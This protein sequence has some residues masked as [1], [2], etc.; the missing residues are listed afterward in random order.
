MSQ[1]KCRPCVEGVDRCA[2]LLGAEA[3]P[4]RQY[5]GSAAVRPKDSGGRGGTWPGTCV[6]RGRVGAGNGLQGREERP[7][8][9]CTSSVWLFCKSEY[10]SG[11]CGS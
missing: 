8:D 5:R 11:R 3:R 6:W 9:A 10:Q 4:D 7:G 1:Y 2:E